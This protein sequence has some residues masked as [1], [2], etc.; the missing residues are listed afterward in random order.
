MVI[1]SR[2]YF[3]YYMDRKIFFLSNLQKRDEIMIRITKQERPS[4]YEP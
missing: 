3:L 2:K 1:F 4:G